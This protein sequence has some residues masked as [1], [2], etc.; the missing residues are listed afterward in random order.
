MFVS[1]VLN[2]SLF[3]FFVFHFVDVLFVCSFL[4]FFLIGFLF[5][6]VPLIFRFVIF[7]WRYLFFHLLCVLFFILFFAFFC[8]VSHFHGER[9]LCLFCV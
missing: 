9:A 5:F 4:F 7:P 3:Y 1:H 6:F 8:F 2:V